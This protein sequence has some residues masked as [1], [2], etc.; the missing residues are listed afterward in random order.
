MDKFSMKAAGDLTLLETQFTMAQSILGLTDDQML[1]ILADPDKHIETSLLFEAEVIK[2]DFSNE[3]SPVIEYAL[4][5]VATAKLYDA[6]SIIKTESKVMLPADFNDAEA[7]LEVTMPMPEGCVPTVIRHTS[8]DGSVIYE[9]IRL[10]DCTV[11]K[12]DKTVTV[13]IP[14][15]SHLV[16]YFEQESAAQTRDN[17]INVPK[18]GDDSLAGLYM[19]LL[20]L[21]TLAAAFCVI[22]IQRR[23]HN[24]SD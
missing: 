19:G 4:N 20:V 9:E 17:S 6:D 13:Y 12:E 10:D 18:T 11:N 1:D 14:H 21:S 2:A 7:N 8:D 23:K 3:K 5:T 16:A 22:M 24:E 15:C